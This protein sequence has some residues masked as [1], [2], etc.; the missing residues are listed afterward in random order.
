MFVSPAVDGWVFAVSPSLP[1]PTVETHHDVGEKFD[2]LLLRLMTRFDDV[3]FFGSYRV[4]DFCAWARAL[5][6]RPTRM[7]AYNDGQI[8]MNFGDQTPEE[9]KL[10]FPDLSGLSPPDANDKLFAVA[11][12]QSAEEERLVA[13]GLSWEEAQAKIGRDALPDE[14]DVVELAALWSIDPTRLSDEDH[15]S[16]LGL[17]A[18]LPEGMTQ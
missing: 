4:T 16:G 6:G 18:R 5:N 3:Q 13:T 17:V 7:F 2:A 14:G 1:Y 9:A 15:P 10:G 11:E 12:E 8:L